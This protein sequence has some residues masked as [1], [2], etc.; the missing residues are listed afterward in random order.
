M[1]KIKDILKIISIPV[2]FSSL[3]CLSPLLIF[4]FGLGSLT[5]A[6]G[7]ADVFYGDYKWYFRIFG[8]LLLAGALFWH[9]WKK[10][11]CSLDAARRQ[12][13][14]IIN[15]VLITLFAAILGYL[16]FLYIVVHYWGVALKL[17]E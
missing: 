3:C 7:L 15:M 1:K 4:V 2:L 6:A 11:V 8:L 16:F 14:K 5:F 13:S 17:W 12:K 9:F 10:G